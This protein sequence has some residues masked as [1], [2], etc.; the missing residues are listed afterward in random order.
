MTSPP[1]IRQ[2]K[3][4]IDSRIERQICIGLIVD[5]RFLRELKPLCSPDSFQASFIR[6]VAGWCLEYHEKYG[7]TPGKHIED[8]YLQHRAEI[9]EDEAKLV[10]EFLAG[11]SEEYER[12]GG[13]N[14]D[15]VR[16]KAEQHIR[17]TSL[18]ALYIKLHQSIIS[19]K[20]EDGE[21]LVK[22]YRRPA[23]R[24]SQGVD[25]LR[26]VDSIVRA[27]VPEESN[28]DIIM[29]LP[30]DL[31]EAA[32]PFER[33]FFVAVQAESG[34]GKTWWLWFMS[35]LAVLSGFNTVF[36]SMEM[37][38]LK[39]IQRGWQDIAGLPSV[40]VPAYQLSRD[41]QL[42][43]P[44]FD[45]EKNQTNECKEVCDVALVRSLNNGEK[46]GL[47]PIFQDAPPDYKSCSKCR[48]TSRF[49]ATAW[50]KVA[51]KRDKLDPSSALRKHAS[52]DRSGVLKRAGKFHLVEFPSR[53]HTMD[54]L[55]TY[56]NNLEYYEDFITSVVVTD[57][58]DKLKWRT[59]GDPR[60]SIGEIWD[61]HKGLA[62][63]R[64]CLVLSASQ[65]NTMRSG[66]QVGRG[67]WGETQEKEHLLD[68][69]IA[70]N[71][72]A[73][74]QASGIMRASIAKKRHGQMERVAEVMVLQQLAIGRPYIDSCRLVREE[75][76]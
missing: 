44:V 48:G 73:Q 8:L 70:F 13:F 31:G 19:G 24:Q 21:E 22:S 67:S 75:R 28:K 52:L 33:G 63:E 76:K 29:R 9:P 45:C 37:S 41:G 71:Q 50:W 59:P 56:L 26:N 10:E 72:S 57:Y 61:S 40:D 69:G 64:H 3:L 25:P 74:D 6:R 1:E 49:R 55:L 30:G 35:Q 5:D 38:T 51:G 66:K 58:A 7:K 16:D 32:G 43:I 39:M 60:V 11:L 12:A 17:L 18:N 47:R 15:Y 34:V 53:R 4:P 14:A 36:F 27:L 65:S 62:Q 20:P 54:D 68:L 46:L 2:R 42:L 23:R